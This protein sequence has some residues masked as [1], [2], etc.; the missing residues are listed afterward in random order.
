MGN[1]V[2]CLESSFVASYGVTNMN[3]SYTKQKTSKSHNTGVDFLGLDL[4]V[5]K[6]PKKEA[7]YETASLMNEVKTCAIKREMFASRLC[8]R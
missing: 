5:V 7:K 4:E 1:T 2:T 8:I 6:G 3:I